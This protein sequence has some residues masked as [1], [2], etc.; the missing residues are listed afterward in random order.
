MV[1]VAP[2]AAFQRELR[3]FPKELDKPLKIG[4]ISADGIVRKPAFHAATGEES[5]S[6]ATQPGGSS[7]LEHFRHRANDTISAE[8]FET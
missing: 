1:Q 2:Q 5:G 7:R 6:Q 4:R 3:G 8:M